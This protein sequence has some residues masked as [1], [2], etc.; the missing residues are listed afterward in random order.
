MQKRFAISSCKIK[1]DYLQYSNKRSKIFPNL[2]PAAS[3]ELQSYRFT[4]L[5]ETEMCFLAEIK[6][7][8]RLAKKYEK[9]L[10]Q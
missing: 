8:E 10:V 1:N 6:E 7:S 4:K 9:I 3:L 5:Y 2:N